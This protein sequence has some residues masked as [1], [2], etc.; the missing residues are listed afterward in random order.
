MSLARSTMAMRALRVSRIPTQ[1]ILVSRSFTSGTTSLE[2]EV[3]PGPALSQT[4]R[5]EHTLRR[6][7]K[8]ANVQEDKD[9]RLSNEKL[10]PGFLVTLDK[11]ALKTPSGTPLRIPR[12]RRLL[13][14]LIANEWE[15]QEQVLKQHTLPLV[16]DK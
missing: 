8:S 10:T 6:F 15:N 5:A 7:W 11:R 13:A 1:R 14:M 2:A 3:R 4:N 16:R 9:G 12:D